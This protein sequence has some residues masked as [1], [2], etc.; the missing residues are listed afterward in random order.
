VYKIR[1]IWPHHEYRDWG[2]IRDRPRPG[3]YEIKGTKYHAKQVVFFPDYV[4]IGMDK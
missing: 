1:D 3:K 4:R 2:T